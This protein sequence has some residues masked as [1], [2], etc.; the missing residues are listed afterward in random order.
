MAPAAAAA[1]AGRPI[2]GHTRPSTPPSSRGSSCRRRSDCRTCQYSCSACC[3]AR[4]LLPPG[5]EL[6]RAA[7]SAA[8][9]DPPQR[10]RPR[11][12][13]VGENER[14]AGAREEDVA[15]RLG[16][17]RSACHHHGPQLLQRLVEK[18]RD[19][20]TVG[21]RRFDEDTRRQCP[22]PHRLARQRDDVGVAIRQVHGDGTALQHAE[23]AARRSSCEAR[24]RLRGERL[25][26]P[27][28]ALLRA[29]PLHAVGS[30]GSLS[31]KLYCTRNS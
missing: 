15:R 18:V 5:G 19:G 20:S 7:R 11:A 13:L 4:R 14:R 23:A 28:V 3:R 30:T 29:R 9:G 31:R 26:A 22:E 21:T 24:L 8:A 2:L 6:G 10:V 1:P 12:R 25:L 17:G 16:A 27:R